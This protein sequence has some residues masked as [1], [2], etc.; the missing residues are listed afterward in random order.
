MPDNVDKLI[1][2]VLAHDVAIPAELDGTVTLSD[3]VCLL[4]TDDELIL[5]A[6][7]ED[8]RDHLTVDQRVAVVKGL[9]YLRNHAAKLAKALKVAVERLGEEAKAAA[10]MDPTCSIEAQAAGPMEAAE[11]YCGARCKEA[12]AEIDAL[13]KESK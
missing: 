9:A 4:A 8:L 12:L 3:H 2:E 6:E 13:C 10:G 11:M 7:P 1:A 5:L